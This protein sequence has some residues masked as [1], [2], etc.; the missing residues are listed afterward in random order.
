M[1]L[2]IPVRFRAGFFLLQEKDDCKGIATRWY[3]ANM[4]LAV[5]GAAVIPG[6]DPESVAHEPFFG[7][8][9]NLGRLWR[10]GVVVPG[11]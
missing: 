11:G 7:K 1:L 8:L 3:F 2:R 4:G 9:M 5:L 10:G 6:F